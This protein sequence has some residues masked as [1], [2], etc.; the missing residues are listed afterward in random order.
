[1]SASQAEESRNGGISWYPWEQMGYGQT[2][3]YRCAALLQDA[4]LAASRQGTD[5]LHR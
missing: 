5:L 3:Q 2:E 1:M 4:P